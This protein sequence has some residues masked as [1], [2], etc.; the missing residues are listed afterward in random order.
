MR[1]IGLAA[2]I[3]VA[4]C[5][6]AKPDGPP[7]QPSIL[8]PPDD[9][10]L[11]A[12]E[13]H[14]N[15]G[16]M[17]MPEQVLPQAEELRALGLQID[18]DQLAD[19]MAHPLGAVIWL[20]GCTASFVSAEGLIITN[21]HCATGALQFNST[22]EQNL[23]ND[24]Y[25]AKTR[26]DEK[27]AG[28]AQRV[29]V[30]QAFKD[31][32]GEVRAG[33][34]AE[35][36][37]KKRYELVEK[38]QKEIVAGCEKGR[39]DVRCNVVSY[40]GGEKFVLV[41]LLELRDVRLVYAPHESIGNYGGEIDNWRW[42][43][44]SGDYSFFRAYVGP[45][46]KPADFDAKN[47]PYKP[48]DHLKIAKK[49]L[50]EHDLVFVAGYPAQT[51]RLKTSR[52]VEEAVSWSY[53]RRQKLCEEYIA[54]LEKLGK[55]DKDLAIKGRSLLRSLNNVLTN[56]KG[57]LDGLVKGGLEKQKAEM[58]KELLA[59]LD[60]HPEHAAA[61]EAV[62]RMAAEYDKH[63][64]R[65]DE[66]AATNEMVGMSTLLGAAD[67]IVHM[68][69]E[70]PKADADRHPDFQERNWK[71]LDQRQQQLQ[72][73]YAR[74]LDLEKLKLSAV[75]AAR[76][77]KEQR[78][79]LLEM[80]LGK[81]EPTPE[82]I[83]KAFAA[84]YET[85]KLEAVEERVRLIHE[86]TIEQLKASQDPF[87]RLAL[88]LRPVLQ[89]FEDENHAYEGATLLD[90]PKYIAAMRAKRGGVL[91][92]DA[93]QT[94]RITWGT[95]RGYRPTPDAEVY[96][97]FTKLS[98]MV[99]KNTGEDPFDAPVAL[100][101]AAKTGPFEPYVHPK[102]KEVPIDF[103]TD[104]DITGGNSGSPTLNARG[105]L[106]GL[107]FDGNYEAMASDWIF[108]PPITRSIHT[109]IRYVLWIMDRVD[110]ADHLLKEMGLTPA[111]P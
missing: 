61:K 5:S 25:L 17:W 38:R 57:Q 41:E 97:P 109:D 70:R 21:H 56:I 99:A 16:G 1:A 24:G 31:V 98:E 77:P 83:D 7:P 93:N 58:E 27:S 85:T 8:V 107:A 80:I 68:A 90:R 12:R 10:T 13:K 66:E 29:Y 55:D 91:A 46:G 26:A 89:Q 23:L 76:L 59:W 103:L 110:K 63:A 22:P 14:E 39:G 72:Q 52:E 40:F 82:A 81:A 71:R 65:R 101:A 67:I 28:P 87:I 73:S 30:T 33:L 19:P 3:L 35:A 105:E 45:D 20:G 18:P 50:D 11:A 51:T 48:R 74:K 37:A 78:P 60:Q 2:L 100:L 36:D 86:A 4:A 53:P 79:K 108:M 42:P 69:L 104:C 96:Y 47:V 15:Q 54:L 88:Q 106:V 94:L 34:E 32:T 92:P 62:T 111:I 64:A 84:L 95:V 9:A 43:R 102:M 49:G 6:P 75:R 44:H